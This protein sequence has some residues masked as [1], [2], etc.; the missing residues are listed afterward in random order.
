MS[1]TI[2]FIR[3]LF[4]WQFT[5]T[6]VRFITSDGVQHYLHVHPAWHSRKRIFEDALLEAMPEGFEAFGKI[7]RTE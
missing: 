6:Q 7:E 1:A 4:F 3:R 2:R 5:V